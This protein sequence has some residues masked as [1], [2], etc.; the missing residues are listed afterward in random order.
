MISVCIATYNG[1]A[2]IKE[3]ITSILKQL[4]SEDEIIIS[5][6]K[7]NDGTVEIIKSLNDER[8]IILT[9]DKN[10]IKHRSFS[11]IYAT[12]NFENAIKKAT[13]DYIFLSDQDDIWLDG[14]VKHFIHELSEK[15]KMMVFSNFSVIDLDNKVS[16]SRY[17][18]KNPIKKIAILNL[19]RMPFFGCTLAFRKELLKYILPFPKQLLLHDNWIGFLALHYGEVSFIDKPFILYRRHINN[20]SSFKGHSKNPIWYRISY[21]L[22]FI[23]Q[24]FQR[25]HN[26]KKHTV[27]I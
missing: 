5:D 20:V 9:N 16:V 7:S 2:Y 25:I 26:K 27:K 13:G 19:I 23:I 14:K 18:K 12:S 3:Q 15:K 21:R 17:Y 11:H 1:Q 22:Q 10:E 6:D 4:S 8:I 24:Y